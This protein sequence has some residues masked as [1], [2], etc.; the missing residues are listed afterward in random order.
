M[1]VEQQLRRCEA[2]GRAF[3]VQYE[4]ESGP[5]PSRER[6]LTT[7]RSIACPH[8]DCGHETRVAGQLGVVKLVVKPLAYAV[9][10]PPPLPSSRP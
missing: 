9:S 3:A 6:D 1:N 7:V 10:G 4:Y 8:H 2:C 5:L